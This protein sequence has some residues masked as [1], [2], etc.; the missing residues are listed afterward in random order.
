MKLFAL[1]S[2]VCGALVSGVCGQSIFLNPGESYVFSFDASSLPQPTASRFDIAFGGYAFE[3]NSFGVGGVIYPS[4]LWRVEMFENS[5]AEI[6]IDVFIQER[7]EDCSM[8]PNFSGAWQ[9]LQ[10]VVRVT[11]IS[12]TRVS[13]ME[14]EIS[15]PSANGY[16]YYNA[17]IQAVPEPSTL[18]LLAAAGVGGVFWHVRRRTTVSRF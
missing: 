10:G 4:C 11:A 12:P 16:L 13:P 7:S 14:V 5:L 8:Q 3:A 2:I 17:Y 9:D 6:P 18:A 1:T 15:V